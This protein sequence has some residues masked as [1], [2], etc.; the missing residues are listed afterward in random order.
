MG[1]PMRVCLMIEGQEDVTW[2]EWLALA[3]ASEEA[4]LE[5]LFTSDHYYSC[6]DREERGSFDAWTLL[7]ALA[8]RTSRLR[9]GTMVSPVTFRHPSLLAKAAVTVDHISA[10][11]VEVGLGAGWYDREHAAYGFPFHTMGVRMEMLD[12]QLEFVHRSWT[13]PSFSFSGRHYEVEECPALPKPVQKPHPNLI[14]AGGGLPKTVRAAA[15]WAYEY[16]TW[17]FAPEE[18]GEIRRRVEEAWAAEGRDPATLVFSVMARCAVG[19]DRAEAEERVRRSIE[20][21]FES[22]EGDP[23]SRSR[24]WVSGT[25][26]EVVEKIRAYEEA[27]VDRIMLQHFDHADVEMV[28]LIGREVVPA[29]L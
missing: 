20:L 8:A 15:R 11:R 16:N 21:T 6:F 10:G 26:R 29:V 1:D 13:E 22:D 4:G 9:L 18:C 2:D 27:G 3:Q 25:V 24:A 7:A 14:V 28:R 17:G 19:S 5:A 12:E 23:L